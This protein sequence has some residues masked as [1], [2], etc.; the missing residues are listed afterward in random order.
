MPGRKREAAAAA[1]EQADMFQ[2]HLPVDDVAWPRACEQ[3]L[4]DVI[5]QLVAHI[6]EGDEEKSGSPALLPSFPN[7]N[8]PQ[9]AEEQEAVPVL[10]PIGQDRHRGIEDRIRDRLIAKVKYRL[11]D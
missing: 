9:D 10:I 11:V 7:Q 2:N 8:Q 6:N 3:C 5:V 4:Q 1:H